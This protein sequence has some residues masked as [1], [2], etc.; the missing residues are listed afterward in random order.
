MI[1]VDEFAYN[2]NMHSKW[3]SSLD[4]VS[5]ERLSSTTAT[6]EISNWNSS[7]SLVGYAT[8][9]YE[10]SQ[11]EIGDDVTVGVELE[12][13]VLT[14]NYDGYNDELIIKIQLDKPDYVANVFIFDAV[15]REVKR[16]TNN[17]L[18]GNNTEINFDLRKEDGNLMAMGAYV[19]YT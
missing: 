17:D 11:T 18:I 5:L 16:I 8:P 10:N 9:T 19:I 4:G 7:S 3:L 14:P 1:V 6:N 15:G 2:E 12:A 13:D